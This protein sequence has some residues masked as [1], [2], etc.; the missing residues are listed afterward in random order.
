MIKSHIFGILFFVTLC[1]GQEKIVLNENFNNN[2]N[3]WDLRPTSK[4]FKVTIEKGVL[5]LEK[6]HKNFDNSSSLT[7]LCSSLS[8]LHLNFPSIIFASHLSNLY[9]QDLWDLR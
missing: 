1:Y 9:L 4:E 6:F 2:R 5:H 8:S 3:S 7:T